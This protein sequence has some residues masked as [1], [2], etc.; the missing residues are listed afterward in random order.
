MAKLRYGQI[1][2]QEDALE[3]KNELLLNNVDNTSDAD[4]PIS[5]A[6]QLEIDSLNST[7]AGVIGGY[8]GKIA[9]SDTPTNDGFYIAVESGTYT[10]AGNLVVTLTNMLSIIVVGNTQTTFE[11]I[12]IPVSLVASGLIEL[13]ETQAVS[14][15]TVYD[16]SKN[17][18]VNSLTDNNFILNRNQKSYTEKYIRAGQIVNTT[19]IIS[20]STN[21][22]AIDYQL[23][24]P[25]TEY[26]LSGYGAVASTVNLITVRDN[27][28]NVLQQIKGLGVVY[29]GEPVTFTTDVNAYDVAIQVT[30]GSGVGLNPS[31]SPYIDTI[32]LN[33]GSVKQEFEPYYIFNNNKIKNTSRIYI[34]PSGSDSNSGSKSSPMLTI[35]SAKDVVKDGGQIILL[36]GDY[37]GESIDLSEVNASI[38]A[39]RGDNVR[40]IYGTKFTSATL[41]AGQTRVYETAYA[42][43]LNTSI[44]LWQHDIEDANT[45]IPLNER[46]VYH[47]GREHRMPCTRIY[48]ASSI[49]EIES[50]TDKLMW[51]QNGGML[52]FSKI[53]S[54]DLSLNPIV[55]PTTSSIKSTNDN[56]QIEIQG[57]DFMYVGL[58]TNGCYG[59]VSD[60]SFGMVNVSGAVVYDKSININFN[61]V[62]VFG[63][64]NDG[65]NG[66]V[67]GNESNPYPFARQISVAFYDCYGHD[68]GDD[69]ESGHEFTVVYHHGGLYEYNGNGVTPASGCHTICY[70]VMARN[71]GDH[72]WSPGQTGTGFSSQGR[73]LDNGVGTNIHCY[74]C[75]SIGNI[76]GFRGYDLDSLFINCVSKDSITTDF[77]GGQNI[78]GV[79]I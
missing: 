29:A 72:D 69:G 58:D 52:Y 53:D 40:V 66:H 3:I 9:I 43:V 39:N 46:H 14:G 2:F 55:I 21:W 65:F 38:I 19:G 71:N 31:E 23:I 67:F 35:N 62:E 48:P 51:Y 64:L 56:T 30:S 10:N 59:N 60:C 1:A 50:T 17:L 42:P 33:L 25:N 28:G 49:A 74:N 27:L 75:I 7:L 45:L 24:L 34:S 20:T 37:T 70:N 15:D 44:W 76:I 4:K 6:T 36:E 73:S 16:Y 8:Q 61:R 26:T 79:I 18:T 77:F 68:N 57:I 47:R 22:L 54:S 5:T 12:E 32:M 78:N 41:T 63:C 13:G 11:L